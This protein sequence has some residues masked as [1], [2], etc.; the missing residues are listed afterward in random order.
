MA[1]EMRTEMLMTT[2]SPITMS[3]FALDLDIP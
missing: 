1:D 2:T 3:P